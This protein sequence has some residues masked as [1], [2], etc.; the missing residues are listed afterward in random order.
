MVM[1]KSNGEWRLTVDYRGLNE[2]TPPLSAAIPDMLELQNE[3]ESKATKWYATTDIANVFFLIP[4]AAECRPQFAFTWRVS[5]IPG[6]DCPR[7]GSCCIV[8]QHRRWKAAVWSPTRQ[9]T[10]TAEA[11]G[12][13]SQFAEVKAIQLALDIAE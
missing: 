5:S 8:G 13:S 10:E 11:Q 3:L 6:I 2:V 9:V 4:L 7:D 1:Q 12:E